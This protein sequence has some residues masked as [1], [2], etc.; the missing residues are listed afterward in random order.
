MSETS[1]FWIADTTLVL[2]WATPAPDMFRYGRAQWEPFNRLG[3]TLQAMGFTWGRDPYYEERYP[4]LAKEHRYGRHGELE[5]KAH[6]YRTGAE[7]AFYQNVVTVNPNGG[8]YDFS[9][10][11]KMPYLVGKRF[12][13][14]L[15]KL[16][17]LLE[18]WDYRPKRERVLSPNPD[19]L[20]YF[21]NWD[22]D[23]ERRLGIHRFK[24]RADGWPDDSEIHSGCD[25]GVD[26][27]GQRLEPGCVRHFRHYDGRLYRARCYPAMN[28]MWTVV[29]GPGR[30]DYTKVNAGRLFHCDPRQER[31][32][33]HPGRKR[34]LERLL[35]AAVEAQEFERAI[36]LRDLLRREPGAAPVRR[37][38]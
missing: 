29:Y 1:R 19:P 24:R 30:H 21:N 16:T 8:Q 2:R 38:A 23:Y 10:R 17:A 15:R 35:Q 37:A 31:R 36:I 25:R 12:E 13:L 34:R 33:V 22:G 9:K 14:A 28:D 18:S 32:R 6:V 3:N 4:R 5:C 27:D 20:A 7:F 26:R 11:Q